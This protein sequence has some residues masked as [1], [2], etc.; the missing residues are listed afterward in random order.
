MSSTQARFKYTEQENQALKEA[1]ARM[2][3]ERLNWKKDLTTLKTYYDE[4][5]S[6]K[7]PS[8]KFPDRTGTAL[9]SHWE[10]LRARGPDNLPWSDDEVEHLKMLYREHIGKFHTI[11]TQLGTGRS[12][13]AVKDKWNQIM[14]DSL[15]GKE[16]KPAVK[17]VVKPIPRPIS[18]KPVPEPEP[19]PEPEEDEESKFD[20]CM[21]AIQD[22]GEDIV[23]IQSDVTD[24]SSEIS[25]IKEWVK[26]I[27]QI[28]Q[29]DVEYV[30][31]E[32]EED[33]TEHE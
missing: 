28:L 12:A 4:C 14:D 3:D 21:K 13:T 27:L 24:L 8:N 15:L 30:Q 23:V 19:E 6:K 20:E 33:T 2:N 16:T 26:Q 1:V 31:P 25:D 10:T 7:S 17:M 11:A 22:I 32:E 18:R 29:G 5:L 9:K